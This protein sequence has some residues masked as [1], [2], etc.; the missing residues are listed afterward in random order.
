MFS[1]LHVTL[2]LAIDRTEGFVTVPLIRL[3]QVTFESYS[4]GCVGNFFKPYVALQVWFQNGN[5]KSVKQY[6][7]V[8]Q[9]S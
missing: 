3:R 7:I 8:I 4:L 5:L 9:G 1:H 2:H 6:Y